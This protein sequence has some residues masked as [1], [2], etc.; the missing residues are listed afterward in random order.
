MQR[1]IIH[2][3]VNGLKRK[4]IIAWKVCLDGLKKSKYAG[5]PVR[6]ILYIEEHNKQPQYRVQVRKGDL[7]KKNLYF[8]PTGQLLDDSITL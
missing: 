4:E 6:E 7:Q 5:W 3:K 1:P 8:S 2:Q